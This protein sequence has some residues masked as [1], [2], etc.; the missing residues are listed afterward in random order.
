MSHNVICMYETMW[1]CCFLLKKS[2]EA[3]TVKTS[4]VFKKT[5]GSLS[6]TVREVRNRHF[7]SFTSE[8]LH[9]TKTP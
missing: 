8:I 4:E 1:L 7:L 5:F 6:D 9:L 3:E 2:I